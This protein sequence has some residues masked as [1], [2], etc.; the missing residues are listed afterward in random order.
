M[1][2]IRLPATFGLIAAC[3][4]VY[5]AVAVVGSQTGTPL[6]VG[7]VSQPGNVLILGA[8]VPLYVA[9]GEAWR[10][11]TSAFLHAG[12]IHLA[13]NMLALYFLGSFA[14]ITFGRNRFFA[15]Y[16]ISGIAG[17][18]ALLY[19]G[20]A[21]SPAV[22][23]SGAIFGLA[24]GVFGFAVRRGTFSTRDPVLRQLLFITAINLAIGATIPGVSNTAHVGGLM[25]GLIFGYLMAPTV[26]SQKRLVAATPVLAAFGLETLLLG[27]WY[28]YVL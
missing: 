15:L 11:V 14:E 12:F 6:N 26:F 7:L 27:I 5:F 20:A 25:G 9:Q 28:L 22:G 24:G 17:G 8:L 3:V 4:S 23:A 13:M 16:F 18:L 21:N 2:S 1:T 10:L 19:F